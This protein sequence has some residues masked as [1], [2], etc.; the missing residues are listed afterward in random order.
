M[1]EVFEPVNWVMRQASFAELTY[2]NDLA[3]TDFFC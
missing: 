1:L 2:L 3:L